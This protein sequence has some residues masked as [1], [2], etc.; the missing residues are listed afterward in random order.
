MAT[1]GKIYPV[2]TRIEIDERGNV[3]LIQN[4]FERVT[5]IEDMQKVAE[6]KVTVEKGWILYEDYEEEYE[7]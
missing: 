3:W 1:A 2:F 5:V 7:Y 6:G 4:N